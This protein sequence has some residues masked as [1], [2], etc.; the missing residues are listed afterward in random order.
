MNARASNKDKDKI[1]DKAK[2]GKKTEAEKARIAE[3]QEKRAL[4][5]KVSSRFR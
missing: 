4:Y 5:P 2:D 1:T 3:L